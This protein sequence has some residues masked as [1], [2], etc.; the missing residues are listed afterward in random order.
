ML[1]A[2][3][4]DALA[5]MIACRSGPPTRRAPRRRRDQGAAGQGREPAYGTGRR[6]RCT[7]GRWRPG[8]QSRTSDTNYK[9]GAGLRAAPRADRRTCG[10]GSP[11]TTCSTSR[12]R[13]TWP[14]RARCGTGSSSRC[15]WAWPPRRR[16][17]CGGTSAA[18][19][20]YTP[21]VH[22]R[23]F[24][25]A[26]AY[27]VRRLEEG[28][29]RTTSCPP[30]FHLSTPVAVRA[31]APSA[32]WRRSTAL[33]RTIPPPNA[34]QDRASRRSSASTDHVRQHA[35]HRSVAGGQPR[36]GTRDPRPGGGQHPRG[37]PGRAATVSAADV[38]DTRIETASRPG[39]R[40]ER[41]PG[42]SAAE[43]LR[44]A[45]AGLAA[46]RARLVEVMACGVREDDRRGRPRGRRRRSTSPTTTPRWRESLDAGRRRGRSRQW[47]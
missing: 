22:P 29:S 43:I 16:P 11:G 31:G 17:R 3:L 26:I 23:E 28:A 39:R 14:G 40:G 42:R 24:D 10:S 15:C 44:R 2:Y 41:V 37:R 27:L 36:L 19:L 35:R 30:L 25:V 46:A 6:R 47:R 34:P 7:G 45:A 12:S 8:R 38:L 5:A 20:L 9:R 1:Q 21:V 32:S 33:D 4:P 13:G 18:L